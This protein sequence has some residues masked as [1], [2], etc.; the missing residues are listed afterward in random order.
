[1]IHPRVQKNRDER[2]WRMWCAVWR[3]IGLVHA[4]KSRP[5]DKLDSGLLAVIT[6][7]MA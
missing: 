5:R 4:R 6:M 7:A 1:M 2:W 3:D